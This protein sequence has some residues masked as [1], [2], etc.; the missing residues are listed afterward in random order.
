MRRDSFSLVVTDKEK[1]DLMAL[2]PLRVWIFV[3]GIIL[4]FN[5]KT[6]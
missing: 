1:L 2:F 5:A 6:S 4:A 3:V